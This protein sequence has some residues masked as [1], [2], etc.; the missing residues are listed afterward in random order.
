MLQL[1]CTGGFADGFSEGGY[2]SGLIDTDNDLYEA[3]FYNWNKGSWY[4]ESS[5][6][7]T[8]ERGVC[9]F[10]TKKYK[11]T[12]NITAIDFKLYDEHINRNDLIKSIGCEN[13][14]TLAYTY[15]RIKPGSINWGFHEKSIIKFKR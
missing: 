11:H 2:V 9:F 1:A 4:I 3:E 12:S 8:D 10:N 15:G 5:L 7:G 14:N 13:F 6:D